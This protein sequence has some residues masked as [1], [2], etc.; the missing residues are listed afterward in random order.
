MRSELRVEPQATA[1]N[2][3]IRKPIEID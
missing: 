3:K 1:E 2:L